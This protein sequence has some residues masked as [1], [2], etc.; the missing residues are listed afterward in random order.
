MRISRV[1]GSVV[2]ASVLVGGLF[3]SHASAA[4]TNV[5]QNITRINNIQTIGTHNSYHVEASPQEKAIR[6]QFD[7][8]DEPALEYTHIPLQQQFSTEN[9]RQVELD[10]FADPVGGLYANPLLRTVAGEGP[11]DPKMYQPGIKVLHIQDV[12]YR[13]NC[14]TLKDCLT[15]IKTWSDA[16]RSHVP[17]QILLQLND[18][19]LNI[20]GLPYPIVTPVLWN[21]VQMDNLDKEIASVFP[22]KDIIKPDNVRGNH[23]TLEDS[24]L[25]NGWPT[26]IGS[27]GKVMFLM[28][29]G[30]TYRDTYLA[31]HPSL[32]GRTLFTNSTPGQPD[33][34][35]V[36]EN[37]P[38]G[39][40][41]TRIQQEVKAG[42]LVRTRADADTVQA[43]TNDT[44]MRDAALASGAQMVSTD[45]P[46]PGISSRFG[47]NYVAQLP[48]GA[49]A[50][51][52]PVNSS[53]YC[54]TPPRP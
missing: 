29:N 38:T 45:Y 50:R 14:L 32:R 42:Y 27:R 21:S 24:V 9:I 43:R 51:C 44:S 18:A 2:L 11:Y 16:N 6:T 54:I 8:A 13:T 15:E 12:D 1:A 30:G 48:G 46:V 20:P 47:T 33:A 28:D 25:H 36:K 7:P 35:F 39:A 52:N 5:G 23:A 19:P 10:L 37:D 17:I 53:P 26:L 4:E 3:V 31:G 49:V 40:N 22:A 34:A 41:F